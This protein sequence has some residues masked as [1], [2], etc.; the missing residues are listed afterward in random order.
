MS[1]NTKGA[2]S[3]FARWTSMLAA[4]LLLIACGGES[5]GGG[6]G[7]PTVSGVVVKGPV[8]GATVI[9]FQGDTE[10]PV[11]PP[12]ATDSEGRYSIRNALNYRGPVRVVATSG[13]YINE[14]NNAD[15]PLDIQLEAYSI[16]ENS[17]G[18]TTVNVTPLTT[19]AAT[20]LRRQGQLTDGASISNTNNLIGQ[21]F[22]ISDITRVVPTNL[23]TKQVSA[24]ALSQADRYGILLAGIGQLVIQR[25]LGQS[26]GDVMDA[27]AD[28]L[29]DGALNST[30]GVLDSALGQLGANNSALLGTITNQAI[31]A[32]AAGT[33]AGASVLEIGRIELTVD[34]AELALTDTRTINATVFPRTTADTA[35]NWS[36]ERPD[37]VAVDQTG[38]VTAVS[39][40][41]ARVTASSQADANI[42]QSIL[43][44]VRDDSGAVP[45]PLLDISL[46]GP[47]TL[48]RGESGNAVVAPI[49][50][51]ALLRNVTWSTSNAEV[52]SISAGGRIEAVGVGTASIKASSGSVVSKT[53]LIVNVIAPDL[54]GIA[55]SGPE[56]VVRGGSITL[57]VVPI[58]GDAISGPAIWSSNRPDIANVVGGQLTGFSVGSV[59]IGASV[60]GFTAEKAIEVIPPAVSGLRIDGV[61]SLQVGAGTVQLTAVASPTNADTG[62]LTWSSDNPNIASVDQNGVLIGNSAGQTTIRVRSSTNASVEGVVPVTVTAQTP[63]PVTGLRIIGESPAVITSNQIID[64]DVEPVPAE[65]QLG[66]VRWTSSNE[67]IATVNPGTGQVQPVNGG[68]VT[69][70]VFLDGVAGVP[71]ATA[72]VTIEPAISGPDLGAPVEGDDSD[73]DDG[74]GSENEEEEEEEEEEDDD[75]GPFNGILGAIFGRN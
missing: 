35:L 28:D 22:G 2:S 72:S 21:A 26:L 15:A 41:S 68:V 20:Q 65:A 71:P 56:R 32:V 39:P 13:R 57:G 53:P 14:A 1:V 37:I 67:S 3:P 11:G 10:E 9:A 75:R 69:I 60:G 66:P 51:T 45:D 50:A 24:G 70:S 6:G 61:T 8:V 27:F 63:P 64:Y 30:D 47:A 18:S 46:V 62:T 54:Q 34:A 36:S 31:Q 16:I 25:D 74:D 73:D 52:V 58:P 29:E 48:V 23:L 42:L 49:P 55:I 17:A 5:G 4:S 40:G 12:V 7:P 33:G 38:L 44:S 19:L 59:I 43:I